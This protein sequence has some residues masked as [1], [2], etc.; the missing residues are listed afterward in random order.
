MVVHVL[1]T[2]HLQEPAEGQQ[3]LFSWGRV[4]GRKNLC[5]NRVGTAGPSPRPVRVGVRTGT[6]QGR[7]WTR[8][9]RPLARRE[10]AAALRRFPW[11]LMYADLFV[12][13]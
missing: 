8:D 3:S 13:L 5:S 6:G 9:A 10:T 11:L 7:R 2:G 4:P 12:V 1:A